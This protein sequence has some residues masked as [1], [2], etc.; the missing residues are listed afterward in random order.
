MAT[1][2][3]T[4]VDRGKV[5]SINGKMTI[6][7]VAELLGV[8]TRTIRRYIKDYRLP[9]EYCVLNNRAVIVINLEHIKDLI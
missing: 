4:K 9:T 3:I 7:Q 6:D 1:K 8:S 5:L 2:V